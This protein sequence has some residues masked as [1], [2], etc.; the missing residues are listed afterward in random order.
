MSE[1]VPEFEQNTSPEDRSDLFIAFIGYFVFIIPLFFANKQNS[2]LIYH[3][4]Q[5]FF[6]FCIAVAIFIFQKIFDIYFLTM[7]LY[8]G[9][10]VLWCFGIT[11]VL[12]GKQEPV[13]VVG[14]LAE[15]LPL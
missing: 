13:P 4:K 8:T 12:L 11:Y 5:S 1:F 10:F 2:F 15:K 7:L 3:L 14:K 9:L 6:I